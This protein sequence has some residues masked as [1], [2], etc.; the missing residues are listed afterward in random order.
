MPAFACVCPV[1][2]TSSIQL[3]AHFKYLQ[4]GRDLAY[5]ELEIGKSAPKKRKY[6]DL[7]MKLRVIVED[8]H[9]RDTTAYLRAIAHAV[10]T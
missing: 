6:E 9:Y 2:N 7:N 3:G 8:Y 10:F 1:C 4:K 5:V